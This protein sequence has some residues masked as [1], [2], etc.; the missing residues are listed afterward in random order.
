MSD[1]CV[2]GHSWEVYSGDTVNCIECD[3]EGEV[4]VTFEP[5]ED[6]DEEED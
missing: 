2:L 3:A 6:D 1:T 4:R 5:E